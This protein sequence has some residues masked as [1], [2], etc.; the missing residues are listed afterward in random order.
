[1]KK[2][3]MEKEFF[4]YADETIIGSDSQCHFNVP[5]PSK[6]KSVN[7]R[8][9]RIFRRKNS[10]FLEAVEK[11]K[12]NTLINRRKIV[13]PVELIDGDTIELGE[14]HLTFNLKD[15]C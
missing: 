9:V 3:K 5:S 7:P 15:A 1:M 2:D 10:L 4:L 11:T 12:D 6:E 14:M 8:H 13:G